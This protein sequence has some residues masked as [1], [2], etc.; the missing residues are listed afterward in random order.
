MKSF[1]T[2]NPY[3][4][5]D[6][7]LQKAMMLGISGMAAVDLSFMTVPRVARGA[8]VTRP[9]NPT[10]RYPKVSASSR[11]ANPVAR[12]VV[13]A[14]NVYTIIFDAFDIDSYAKMQN[15]PI[16]APIILGR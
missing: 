7:A 5:H 4:V 11:Y 6:R 13:I 2:S 14:T 8:T 15:M 10:P 1:A 3:R 12:S 9:A 16:V